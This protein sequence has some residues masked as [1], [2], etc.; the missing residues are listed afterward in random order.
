MF[1]RNLLNV[2]LDR[3]LLY[4]PN[5]TTGVLPNNTKLEN[6]QDMVCKIEDR[7]PTR[8]VPTHTSHLSCLD[9]IQNFHSFWVVWEVPA[10]PTVGH[11]Q[12][13]PFS[14]PFSKSPNTQKAIVKNV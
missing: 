8:T 3:A 10:V 2:V 6:N 7:V 14:S 4:D 9:A 5:A 11:L 13:W 12:S 1:S